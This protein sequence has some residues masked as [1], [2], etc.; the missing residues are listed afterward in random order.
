MPFCDYK[1]RCARQ[2]LVIAP[3]KKS[4]QQEA[5]QAEKDAM[6][7]AIIKKR[8]E[9]VKDKE[10]RK[11]SMVRYRE[12]VYPVSSVVSSGWGKGLVRLV[13]LNKPVNPKLIKAI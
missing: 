6:Q 13:G 8:I 3:S 12:K 5:K 10:I 7:L 1:E 9:L 4:K 11:G 2:L